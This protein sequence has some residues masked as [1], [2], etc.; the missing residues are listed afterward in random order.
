MYNCFNTCGRRSSPPL[1]T[2]SLNE[3]LDLEFEESGSQS[4]FL[5]MASKKYASFNFGEENFAV[6]SKFLCILSIVASYVKSKCRAL[7][8]S[9]FAMSYFIGFKNKAVLAGK[10]L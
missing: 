9:T 6:E 4:L 5:I 7:T 3:Q 1:I 8:V 10:K 2:L